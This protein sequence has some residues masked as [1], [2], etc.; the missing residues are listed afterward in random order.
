MGH[1]LLPIHLNVRGSDDFAAGGQGQLRR[2]D[3]TGPD[4]S[5]HRP[6]SRSRK[7]M[8]VLLRSTSP[9]ESRRVRFLDRL[10]L[11]VWSPGQ[12]GCRQRN[13]GRIPIAGAY[14]RGGGGFECSGRSWNQRRAARLHQG[15]F[16]RPRTRQIGGVRGLRTKAWLQPRRQARPGHANET[17]SRG[18]RRLR[19]LEAD[20]CFV[21]GGR[22]GSQS[23]QSN[24]G[25]GSADA[26]AQRTGLGAANGTKK[27]RA[28]CGSGH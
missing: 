25:H 21:T 4:L 18:S 5:G 8:R 16:K 15:K 24:P 27:P 20:R 26:G 7:P 10:A 1:C 28:G 9:A 2:G 3:G 14:P 11:R 23:R 17:H 12:W 13:R 22:R 19:R 6:D